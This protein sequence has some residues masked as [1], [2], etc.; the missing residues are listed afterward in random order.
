MRRIIPVL[1]GLVLTIC[2]SGTAMAQKSEATV[3][4]SL[5]DSSNDEP[6]GFATV[7]LTAKG[8]NKVYK[9]ALSTSEG[10]VSFTGVKAGT[11]TL[12]AEMMGYKA[13]EKEITVKENTA[14][15]IGDLK[16]E[17][18]Q[19]V[20]DASKVSAVGNPIV[21]K[22]D[23]IEYNASSFKTTENDVLEDLLKKL[24]GVEVSESGAITVNGETVTQVYIDGKT[25]F[26]DDPQ[27]ASKNIPAKIV[28]K[29]K[30]V[31]KKSE[32]A[33]FTG[34]DDGEEET[35]LDLTVQQGMMDGLIGNILAGAGHDIPASSTDGS[36]FQGT[37]YDDYRFQTNGFIGK[38]SQ[39]TQF[40]ILLNA[41]N[42]NNRGFND[43][44]GGR[45]GG[46]GGGG[47]ITTS[48]M[49]GLNGGGNYFD[50]RMEL[51]G[52]YMFTGSENESLTNSNRTT[53]R[54]DGT[55]LIAQTDGA[56][57]N[58][59]LGHRFGVRLEHKFSDNTSIIF[60]PQ[61]DFGT[62]N[63]MR[64]SDQITSVDDGTGNVT[65]SNDG[66]SLNSGD[67][68]NM[69]TS[70]DFMFRQ[71]LGLPG[72]TLTAN[73]RYNYSTTE[74]D[75]YTQSLTNN[76]DTNNGGAF[77]NRV[78]TNQRTDQTSTSSSISGRFNYTEPMGNYF[79]LEANYEYSWNKSNSQ[80]DAFDSGNN[81][82]FSRTNPLYVT[83]GETFNSSYSNK[84]TNEYV[85]QTIGG[86]VL[87]QNDR[88]R[89]QV[90][91]SARPNMTRNVTE[92]AD[93][94][95]D[96]T[97]HVVNWSPQAMIMY[98]INDNMSTRFFYR[99]NSRQPSISQL[100]PV[101]DNTNAM[102]VSLGN[103]SLAPYFSHNV[104]G[105]LRYNN[106]QTF[107]SAN[108][109]FNVGYNQNP[110]VNATM[111]S[112]N[113]VTFSMP[114]NGPSSGNANVNF[115]I[116]QPIAKSNFSISTTT[117]ISGSQSSSYEGKNIAVEDYYDSATGDFDYSSF[118]RAYPD[119]D[120]N[121]DF[122]T[123]TTTNMNI[124]ERLNL[125]YR[126]DYLEV[127]LGGST[128]YSRSWFSVNEIASTKTWNNQVNGSVTWTLDNAGFSLSS[129][130]NYNWYRGYTTPLEDELIINAEVSKLIFNNRVTMALRVADLLGQTK[131]LTVS[132]SDT[133]HLEQLSNSLGRYF[134]LSF[135]YRFG[136]F[137][138][139]GGGM[140]G[141]MGG[142]MR[143]M[144]RM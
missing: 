129:D 88:L 102:R 128:R 16:M 68:K 77:L 138:G 28:E 126:S 73:I 116:N 69:G 46:G 36:S 115:F 93:Y 35:V 51:M 66:F 13:F 100:M 67:N 112:V 142:G 92:R 5:I 44:S 108:V 137:G 45:M 130:A 101:P 103:P 18:D 86:N 47:G 132:D 136:T 11:Y 2:F 139:R 135:T 27:L 80:K 1:V 15:A 4:A 123:N 26:L 85:N 72:R 53:Y 144:G 23:T 21:V 125:T 42:A 117:G 65:L 99:G 64:A 31:Q 78:I 63:Y 7:S 74:T 109:R 81:D 83:A 90:G 97:I 131:T 58:N 22:K 29:V 70:G 119:F 39:D 61:I 104:N 54:T 52:N 105:E 76:Y 140:R 122:F 91:V 37:N 33:E 40:S 6:V 94:Q 9:Y 106:R 34:I 118:L 56:S 10:A 3:T 38:F 59:T 60:E 25:F 32:Q 96:T 134:I 79:Y 121:P 84:T 110:I 82:A 57:T 71:R 95:L 120:N 87:Y 124:N 133:Y 111:Y 98:D 141:G 89:A 41:N 75:G 49:A 43:R 17:V 143:G 114:V 50:D 113:N 20:L 14:N 12:K 8:A 30:V 107:S 19:E 127:R 48:Y 62:G 24:P 55:N